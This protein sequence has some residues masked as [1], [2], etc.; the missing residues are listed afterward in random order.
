M[1]PYVW[2]ITQIGI[3]VFSIVLADKLLRIHHI[4]HILG[5]LHPSSN[6]IGDIQV[7][8]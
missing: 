7:S 1:H 2:Q 8:K 3:N 5:T 4:S 6:I